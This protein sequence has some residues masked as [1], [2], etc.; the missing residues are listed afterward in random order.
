MFKSTA[1]KGFQLKFENGWT[2]S[3][4][5]GTSN[6]CSNR[7]LDHYDL[8]EWFKREPFYECDT[9]EIAMWGSDDKWYEFE[10]GDTVK[11]WCTPNEVA[12]WIEKCS[13]F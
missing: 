9:A 12:E 3:V 13:K 2:I 10:N 5:W 1:H 11:G 6:Y 8:T 4:Q 7:S